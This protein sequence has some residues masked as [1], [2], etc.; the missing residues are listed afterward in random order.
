MNSHPTQQAA[1]AF[2][3]NAEFLWHQRF[4]LAPGVYTPG[5]NDMALFVDMAGFP[6]DLDG[7]SVLDIG[8]TNGGMAFELERRGAGRV[9]A[10]D[11]CDVSRFGFAQI[12]QLLGSDVEY[13]RKTVYELPSFLGEKFDIVLFL[14]V[15]Y[16]LRHPLLAL[17][18]VRSLTRD[19]ALIET[20]VCDGALGTVANASIARFHRLDELNGD[21]SNWFEPSVATF[22]NWCRSCGLEPID[23]RTWPPE[24]PSRSLVTTVPTSGEPEYLGISYE[25][26]LTCTVATGYNLPA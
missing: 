12:K 4:E 17:D 7:A 3:K 24:A 5:T 15:L 21:G 13:V 18:A 9:V 25:L 20:A 19:R 10:V 23:V 22:T 14:G 2:V 11:I 1:E 8:T 16:H 6:E 26:P